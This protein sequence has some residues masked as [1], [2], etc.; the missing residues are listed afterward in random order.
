MA[1]NEEYI[2][3][4]KILLPGMF[5][6]ELIGTI[7]Q[8]LILRK[9]NGFIFKYVSKQ[10]LENEI[11]KK[12][13]NYKNMDVFSCISLKTYTID[14]CEA[15]L[16][17]NINNLHA[18]KKYGK[19]LKFKAGID[20]II[21][22]EDA[23]ELYEFIEYCYIKLRNNSVPDRKEKCGF[24]LIDSHFIVSYYIKDN[25]K[26]IPLFYFENKMN[27]LIRHCAI[28]LENWDLA[29][30]KF[31][32][33]VQGVRKEFF[34]SDSCTVIS[35][36]DIK[37]YCKS[38]TTFT[39][40]WPAKIKITSRSDSWIRTSDPFDNP[41]TVPVSKSVG[42]PQSVSIFNNKMVINSICDEIKCVDNI[43]NNQHSCCLVDTGTQN[44]QNLNYFHSIHRAPSAEC[45]T[46]AAEHQSITE[47]I[48]RKSFMAEK[49][50]SLENKLSEVENM[51]TKTIIHTKICESNNDRIMLVLDEIKKFVIVHNTCNDDTFS[52]VETYKQNCGDGSSETKLRLSILEDEFQKIRQMSALFVKPSVIEKNLQQDIK[53]RMIG[54]RT[55][56]L[57][58]KIEPP[59]PPPTPT[60]VLSSPTRQKVATPLKSTSET[61]YNNN[62]TRMKISVEEIRNV[63]LRPLQQ[64]KKKK[65]PIIRDGQ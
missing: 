31:W 9:I 29:Y 6:W 4:S 25:Q 1:S 52:T 48:N 34:A 32:F 57:L 2:N 3:N 50:K 12:Y 42:S 41:N 16:L 19:K 47:Q 61:C 62:Y 49:L 55:E 35:L 37:R 56:I 53:V 65:F 30:L 26:F 38:E 33:K 43:V 54:E 59:P 22:L 45:S 40:C 15:K 14:K 21:S 17:T 39:E 11:L 63:K 28:K 36:N 44:I 58:T 51:L 13:F 20:W 8:P 27:D 64:H 18:G 5:A 60:P 23:K 46:F 10:T 24:I 7:Y